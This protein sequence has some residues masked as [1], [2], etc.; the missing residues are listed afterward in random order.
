[1]LTLAQ[2][3]KLA[4]DLESLPDEKL[5]ETRDNLYQLAQLALDSYLEEKNVP[6]SQINLDPLYWNQNLNSPRN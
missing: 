1:M 5:L 4:P 2:C 3:R 6:P